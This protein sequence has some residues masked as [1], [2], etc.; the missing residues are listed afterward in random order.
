MRCMT[1]TAVRSA[2]SAFGS[3]NSIVPCLALTVAA[4]TPPKRTVGCGSSVLPRKR[5]AARGAGLVRSRRRDQKAKDHDLNVGAVLSGNRLEGRIH[6]LVSRSTSDHPPTL[7][8][9]HA[10]AVTA[11]RSPRPADR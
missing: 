10:L 8:V 3:L 7:V 4:L 9:A 5:V 2:T 11:H 1:L 6:A